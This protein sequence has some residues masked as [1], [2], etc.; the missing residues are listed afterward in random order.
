MSQVRN[1]YCYTAA[2]GVIW[3]TW[4]IGFDYIIV[5]GSGILFFFL[6]KWNMFTLRIGMK[7]MH[8]EMPDEEEQLEQKK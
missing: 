1:V 7:V 4:F 6:T 5:I 3:I 8:P 2:I